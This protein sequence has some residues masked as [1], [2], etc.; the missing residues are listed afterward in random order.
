MMT[1]DR[2]DH[3]PIPGRDETAGPGP[4]SPRPP[5]PATPQPPAWWCGYLA[6]AIDHAA[7][8]IERGDT[9]EALRALR[10]TAATYAQRER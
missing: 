3:P 10:D 1:T 6:Q 4:T 9:T 7:A 8:A 5:G 2:P